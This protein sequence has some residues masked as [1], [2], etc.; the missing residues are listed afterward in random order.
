MWYPCLLYFQ[1]G[2]PNT[3]SPESRRRL[4]G[5]DVFTSRIPGFSNAVHDSTATGEFNETEPYA[6]NF[7]FPSTGFFTHAHNTVCR[8]FR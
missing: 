1:A 4:N 7:L 8:V 2:G 6:E 3:F 5:I